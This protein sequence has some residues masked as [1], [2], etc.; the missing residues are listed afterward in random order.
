MNVTS[1]AEGY[2][3]SL[4]Q[5]VGCPHTQGQIWPGFCMQI[6]TYEGFR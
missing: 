3:V 5:A 4:V 6:F 1:V 2:G